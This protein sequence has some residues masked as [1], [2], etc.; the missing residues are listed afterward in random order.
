[1]SADAV[2]DSLRKNYTDCKIIGTDI[3]RKEW[4]FLSDKV[5]QFYKVSRP[6][7]PLY[8]D[9]ILGIC[10][11]HS[12]DYILPL[13][14]PE[15]DKLSASYQSFK[16]EAVTLALDKKSTI[17]TCR[18]KE[19]FAEKLGEISSINL[20]PSFSVSDF[21]ESCFKHPVVAKPKEGRSSQGVRYINSEEELSKVGDEYILQKQISGP[22]I[23]VDFVRDFLGNIVALPRKELIRS[24]NG[25]GLS[26]EVF[27]D[28]EIEQLVTTIAEALDIHGCMNMEL[29]YNNGNYFLMDINPRFSAGVVFSKLAGYDFVKNHMRVFM[30]R[31]IEPLGEIS[32]SIF[33]RHF[34]NYMK[35]E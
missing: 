11:K 21:K 24:S 12:V 5:D 3:H 28:K 4:L 10:R 1:M 9:Q 8:I 23:A 29:I 35:N 27:K 20:I 26:V 14:D 34:S 18:S 15:V 33:I 7:E 2:L 25:A 13:T 31:P 30:N 17:R 32:S 6:E 16:E 19:K 22:I